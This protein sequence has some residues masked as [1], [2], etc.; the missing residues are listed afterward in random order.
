MTRETIAI[1][2]CYC[3]KKQKISIISLLYSVILLSMYFINNIY[4]GLLCLFIGLLI[5]IKNYRLLLPS[6]IMAALLGDFFVITQGQ[7]ISRYLV[8]IIVFGYILQRKF[9]LRANAVNK[10]LSVFLLIFLPYNLLTCIISVT[11]SV[12]PFITLSLDI[13]LMMIIANTRADNI[14]ALLK[15]VGASV[16]IFGL[17]LFGLSLSVG[18]LKSTEI[19]F[20]E[21][22]NPNGISMAVAQIAAYS[23]ACLFIKKIQV[24]KRFL[25]INIIAMFIT[26]LLNGSRTSLLA[27]ALMM[28]ILP[29][30]Y[31]QNNKRSLYMGFISI[32]I[33]IVIYFFIQVNSDIFSIFTLSGVAGDTLSDRFIILNIVATKIIPNNLFF[34]VGLGQD[35]VVSVVSN[36]LS[37]PHQAHNIILAILAETGVIGFLLYGGFFTSSLKVFIKNL[38]ENE[39]MLVPLSMTIVALLN[40]IGEDMF[41][42]RFFWIAFGIGYMMYNNK[43]CNNIGKNKKGIIKE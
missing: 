18:G 21:A 28:I 37:R 41:H 7:G 30:I 24:N 6:A 31:K 17:L 26:V 25:V 8:L 12:T 13:I 20:D 27:L 35:N 38:K 14:Y 19:I 16:I 34:G 29:M 5:S 39:L 11:G 22:L 36:Y 32:I 43:K 23:Y 3:E 4:Y 1:S 33:I 2:K 10:K 15:N 9:F 40:G 42:K